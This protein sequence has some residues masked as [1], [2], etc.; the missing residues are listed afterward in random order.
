[1]SGYLSVALLKR[2]ASMGVDGFDSQM[3][4]TDDGNANLRRVGHVYSALPYAGA[5]V[6]GILLLGAERL[7]LFHLDMSFRRFA[8]GHQRLSQEIGA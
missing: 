4:G 3:D 1:M 5:P 6:S 2:V 7:H 8:F